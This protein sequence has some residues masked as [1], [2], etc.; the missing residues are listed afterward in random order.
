MESPKVQKVSHWLSEN[1]KYI[2]IHGGCSS[3]RHSLLFGGYSPGIWFA[4]R[5]WV[6]WR[7][8]QLGTKV[9]WF[10]L[11]D[12]QTS[13]KQETWTTHG[14]TQIDTTTSWFQWLF[15]V[16]LKGGRW[17]IIP[18]LAV[19]TTYILPIGGLYVTY[20]LLGEPETTI[21]G[22]KLLNLVATCCTNSR[23]PW[24]PVRCCCWVPNKSP[25]IWKSLSFRLSCFF[26]IQT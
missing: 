12:H 9:F 1:R 18:Q 5:S 26:T 15:L 2:F 13:S 14:D 24:F 11:S 16:P 21:D 3:D 19:Y 4:Y 10:I 17:H 8:I 22:F 23:N 20:H 25:A 6:S 7:L